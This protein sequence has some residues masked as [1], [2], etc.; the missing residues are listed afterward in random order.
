MKR[1]IFNAKTNRYS[2]LFNGL[3]SGKEIE[4]I[5][6]KF[7]EI[8]NDILSG[9]YDQLEDTDDQEAIVDFK[10]RYKL[11]ITKY[12]EIMLEDWFLL[13]RLFFIANPDLQY[14]WKSVKQGFERMIL[15]AIYNDGMIT[16]VYESMNKKVKQFFS[17]F[18]YVFSLN[19][20]NNIELLTKRDVMH[21]HGDYSVPADSENPCTVEGFIRQQERKLVA[22]KEFQ[23]CFCNALLDY[24]GEL[25]YK[26]AKNIQNVAAEM[27]RWLEL[28]RSDET[29]YNK[30]IEL[31]KEKNSYAFQYIN[32]YVQNPALKIGTD[33]HFNALSNLNGELYIIG[34]SPSND[35]HIF[36]CINESDVESVCYYCYTEPDVTIPITKPYKIKSVQELW[37]RLDAENRKYNCNYP[38]PNNQEV[39]KFIEVFNALSFDPISKQQI[40]DEVN[41]IPQFEAYRLCK[42]VRKELLEQKTKG[43]PKSEEEL[44]QG[45]MEISRIALREGVLPSALFLLY[46]MNFKDYQL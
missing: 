22:I 9:N 14:E 34:L 7:I 26:H 15:D 2:P 45:F 4:N 28:S 44:V 37:R 11:P 13:I 8:A 43:N 35:S 41:S 36:R 12:Y 32:T 20:D 29:E 40:I 3:I 33:Y 27:N 17:Q 5:F 24:S 30:Q 31:L 1:I 6:K 10:S 42:N 21:L 18:D 23:H 19:Y 46:I 39:D 16:K 25:K 38:I